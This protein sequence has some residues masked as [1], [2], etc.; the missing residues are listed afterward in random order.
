[1]LNSSLTIHLSTAAEHVLHYLSADN[2]KVVG[3]TYSAIWQLIQDIC[4]GGFFDGHDSSC[5]V[6]AS[7]EAAVPAANNELS[8]ESCTS[9]EVADAVLVDDNC[10][11]LNGVTVA[12]HTVSGKCLMFFVFLM[13]CTC[14]LKLLLLQNFVCLSLSFGGCEEVTCSY[15]MQ[16]GHIIYVH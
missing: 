1:L 16:V 3:T 2:D 6:I 10:H 4:K 15:F 7:N 5:N 8:T 12:E 11:V 9:H 13:L 14:C